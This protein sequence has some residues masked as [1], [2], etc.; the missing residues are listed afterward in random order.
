MPENGRHRLV[1]GSHRKGCVNAVTENASHERRPLP[2]PA[3][4][5]PERRRA[6]RL[7]EVRGIVVNSSVAGEQASFAKVE[8]A[9]TFQCRYCMPYENGANIL[10]GR[11]LRVPIAKAW[12]GTRHFD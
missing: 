8:I 10:I 4:R 5:V 2:L 1:T 6:D 7:R 3:A 11:G 12:P 9:G